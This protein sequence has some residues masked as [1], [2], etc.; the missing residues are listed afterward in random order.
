[1]P[2]VLWLPGHPVEVGSPV[3]PDTLASRLAAMASPTASLQSSG[4]LVAEWLSHRLHAERRAHLAFLRRRLGPSDD[5]EDLLQQAMARA[6]EKVS[7][8]REPQQVSS[9]FHRILRRTVADHHARATSR[10]ARMEEL[11]PQLQTSSDGAVATCTCAVRLLST[12]KPE[13]A[14]LVKLVD[15]DDQALSDAARML[16][17]TPG[18]AA[19]RLHRARKAIREGLM[20]CCGMTSFRQ[21]YDCDCEVEAAS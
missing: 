2:A 19:V 6:V 18:N 1:M 5:A 16:A 21:G 14:A 12:L 10:K 13:Q 11:G 7:T 4:P 17:I 8:L 3:P 20:K 9:W 15:L